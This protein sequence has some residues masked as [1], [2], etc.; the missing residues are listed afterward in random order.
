MKRAKFL[1]ARRSHQ[2]ESF[3]R[4]DDFACRNLDR[5]FFGSVFTG[6]D[7]GE[8][9]GCECRGRIIRER[10]Q[11]FFGVHAICVQNPQSFDICHR[12][13][14]LVHCLIPEIEIAVTKRDEAMS[15]HLYK[16]DST[17]IGSLIYIGSRK[18]S[19]SA[20]S[21]IDSL[22]KVGNTI[23]RG[24]VVELQWLPYG[25]QSRVSSDYG[26]LERP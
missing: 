10:H 6:S 17:Q 18:N 1:A 14:R 13:L 16:L 2:R 5:L 3:V 23:N 22:R 8:L 24:G 26:C 21:I 19:E 20:K 7:C 11:N 15:R 12:V 9:F 4:T 25:W